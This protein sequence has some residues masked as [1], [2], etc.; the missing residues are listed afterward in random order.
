V[1]V[2]LRI[3]FRVIPPFAGALWIRR[4]RFGEER[5]PTID[6]QGR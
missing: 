2:F 4:R 5:S 1:R 3:R 6:Q